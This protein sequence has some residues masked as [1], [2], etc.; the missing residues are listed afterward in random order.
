MPIT[1][2]PESL[3]RIA[4]A[5]YSGVVN[6]KNPIKLD[7]KATPWRSY[8]DK[9]I[10][11]VPLAGADGAVIKWQRTDVLELQAFERKDR[12]GFGEQ[13]FLLDGRVPLSNIHMGAEL[14]HD[15]IEALGYTIVPNGVR[16]KNFAK[17]DSDSDPYRLINYV[18][19]A[20]EAMTDKNMIEED[21]LLLLDNATS[22]KSPQGLDSMLPI[23]SLPGFATDPAGGTFGY[24]DAGTICGRTRA[25]YPEEL[26]HFVWVGAGYGPTG[27]LRRA[28][29]RAK[30]EAQL[31][32]RGRGSKGVQ[33]IMGGQRA[34]EKYVQFATTNAAN[35]T[36]ATTSLD[37]GGLS[38][39]DIGVPDSGLYFEGT[40]II[41]N[42]TFEV[43]DQLFPTTAVK[44]TNRLYLI[45]PA[46]FELCFAPGKRQFFSAPMDAFDQ[47][48]TRLSLDSKLMLYPKIPNASAVVSVDP[49]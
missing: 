49:A 45:D 33:F 17:A 30:R 8:L 20:I 47:R 4:L 13:D 15:D 18:Q 16:G 32:S 43:L 19:A 42:P 2:T 24:Y 10:G 14:V 11:S 34:I 5:V 36:T 37:K 12:L 38:R 29:T 25:S 39:L 23:A 44:W 35:I 28:L 1:H 26:Q 6:P 21:K 9:H 40:P 3:Q 22:P 48:V 27:S 41:H 7:R 46:H 31:R